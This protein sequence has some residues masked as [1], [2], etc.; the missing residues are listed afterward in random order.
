ME[1][2]TQATIITAADLKAQEWKYY[3]VCYVWPSYL[4]S[5]LYVYSVIGL[6]AILYMVFPG[7][8]SYFMA[9][10]PDA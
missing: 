3:F 1:R 10:I 5:L 2:P 9:R 8:L 4:F 6:W 7:S